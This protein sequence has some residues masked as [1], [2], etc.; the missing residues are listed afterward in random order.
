MLGEKRRNLGTRYLI[1]KRFISDQPNRKKLISVTRG[2]THGESFFFLQN[3]AA[4][5]QILS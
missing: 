1:K 3:T 2:N 4:Y 5:T